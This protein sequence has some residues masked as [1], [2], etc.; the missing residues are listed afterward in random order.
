MTKTLIKI[1]NK[2][3]TLKNTYNS[4]RFENDF[5]NSIWNDYARMLTDCEGYMTF[6]NLNTLDFKKVQEFLKYLELNW[7]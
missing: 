7:L 6:E 5:K 2:V 4:Y 3:F 1:N